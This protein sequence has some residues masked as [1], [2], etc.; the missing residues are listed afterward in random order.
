MVVVEGGRG[1][2]GTAHRDARPITPSP[3]LLTGCH[4]RRSTSLRGASG[5]SAGFFWLRSIRTFTSY[6][7]FPSRSPNGLQQRENLMCYLAAPRNIV[8]TVRAQAGRIQERTRQQRDVAFKW[9]VLLHCAAS[10]CLRKLSRRSNHIPGFFK[11][12]CTAQ[13][14]CLLGLKWCLIKHWSHFP[15][16]TLACL[17]VRSVYLTQQLITF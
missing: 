7:L 2:G 16:Q 12:A 5:P 13:C 3:P 8:T 6:W 17:L 1:G 10:N 15:R 9:A 14:T 4:K 11:Q